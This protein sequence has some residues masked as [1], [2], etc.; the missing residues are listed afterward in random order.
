MMPNFALVEVLFCKVRAVII[1]KT[2]PWVNEVAENVV[3]AKP[4]Y[5]ISVYTGAALGVQL[6]YNDINSL[7][8]SLGDLTLWPKSSLL[9]V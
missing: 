3:R 7:R 8:Y 4:L 2:V 9:M 1:L 6:A 5:D